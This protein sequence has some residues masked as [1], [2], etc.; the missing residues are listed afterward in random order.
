MNR[1]FWEDYKMK[2]EVTS[3]KLASYK[4]A[5][6]LKCTFQ[7]RSSTPCRIFII[8]IDHAMEKYKLAAVIFSLTEH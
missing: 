8:N 6:K 5:A 3:L 2:K 7:S 4:K 1:K